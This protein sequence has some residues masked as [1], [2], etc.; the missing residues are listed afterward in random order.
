MSW[1]LGEIADLSKKAARGAGFSWGLAEEAAWAVR[2]L[3]ERGLPGPEALARALRNA[4]VPCP[5]HLGASIADKQDLNAVSAAGE[6]ASPI[7][8]IPFFSRAV[9]RGEGARFILEDISFAVGWAGT[10]VSV[11]LPD[12]GAIKYAGPCPEP[13]KG[14][15]NTRIRD[16]DPAA[17]RELELLAKRVYAP[18]TARSREL[19]AGAARTD[20]D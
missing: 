7:L 8:C 3:A 6:V 17:L 10:D 13:V 16:L 14:P 15:L 11:P 12:K 9:V 5:V 20:N 4:D 19:G 1:S 18:A 2:W